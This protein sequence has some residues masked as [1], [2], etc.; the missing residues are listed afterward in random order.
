MRRL[1]LRPVEARFDDDIAFT[2]RPVTLPDLVEIARGT[3][4]DT[5]LDGGSAEIDFRP[6][7]AVEIALRLVD[8]L[9][10]GWTLADHEGRPLPVTRAAAAQLVTEEPA[11]LEWLFADVLV[12]ALERFMAAEQEKNV[13]APSPTG[14]TAGVRTTARP[15]RKPAKPAPRS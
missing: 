10:T 6:S 7:E 1:D 12:P 5:L 3:A 14:A 8:T 15:A 9:A 13:S 2:F 11:L 4:M